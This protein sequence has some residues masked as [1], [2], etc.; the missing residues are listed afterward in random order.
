MLSP[1]TTSDV[2]VPHDVVSHKILNWST[3]ILVM[4]H[5]SNMLISLKGLHNTALVMAINSFYWRWILT[6][7][8]P[9]FIVVGRSLIFAAELM[10]RS[11]MQPMHNFAKCRQKL[12]GKP[13]FSNVLVDVCTGPSTDFC[14]RRNTKPAPTKKS[15][16]AMLEST[17]TMFYIPT[18]SCHTTTA[19]ASVWDYLDLLTKSLVC[20]TCQTETHGATGKQ[21]TPCLRLHR[22]SFGIN[23]W[24]IFRIGRFK[25]KE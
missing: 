13:N 1:E 24:S 6:L 14:S 2:A 22:P 3:N 8:A 5:H 4:I 15:F 16:W 18:T 23:R 7:K 17:G 12:H 9:I 11:L 21:N 19:L 10:K 25:I 20:Q